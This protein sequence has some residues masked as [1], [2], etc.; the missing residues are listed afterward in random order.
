MNG[1]DTN[2][3]ASRSETE[4]RRFGIPV[5]RLTLS[6]S[7][8]QTSDLHHALAA[9]PESALL[10]LNLVNGDLE[11]I[12]DIEQEFERRIVT[13]TPSVNWE[14]TAQRHQT[15]NWEVSNERVLEHLENGRA[16]NEIPDLVKAS[17]S[18][19]R[20][21]HW[22]DPFLRPH[23]NLGVAYAEWA[24][25]ELLTGDSDAYILRLDS[26]TGSFLLDQGMP[27]A[28]RRILLAA[29]LQGFRNQGLYTEMLEGY[30]EQMSLRGQD[31][32]CIATQVSNISVQRRWASLGFCPESLIRHIHIWPVGSDSIATPRTS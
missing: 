30:L 31:R 25:N 28:G 14:W 17:F 8:S 24:S 32:V 3:Q 9:M 5:Y 13:C 1:G 26:D 12:T 11:G 10:L 6:N 16:L 15:S 7:A 2:C 23:L 27:G 18:D 4:S 22:E 21:H 19:Y 29:T 20:N